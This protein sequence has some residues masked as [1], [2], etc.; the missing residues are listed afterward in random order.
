MIRYT[1]PMNGRDGDPLPLAQPLTP[2]EEEILI[3]ID[4]GLSN[5]RSQKN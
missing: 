2:R 3:L 1:P 5:R 4:E